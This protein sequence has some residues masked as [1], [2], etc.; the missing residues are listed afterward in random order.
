VAAVA[1]PGL[2]ASLLSGFDGKAREV[3]ALN[4]VVEVVAHE[5]DELATV[6]DP[7]VSGLSGEQNIR[8]RSTVGSLLAMD[9]N[10]AAADCLDF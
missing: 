1:L 6:F 5:H 2:S 9:A 3:G 10:H 4:Y 7:A 8:S